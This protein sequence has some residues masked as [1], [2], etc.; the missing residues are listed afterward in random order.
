[1]SKSKG[2]ASDGEGPPWR[3]WVDEFKED[4]DQRVREKTDAAQGGAR[5]V[6]G[7]AR[8]LRGGVEELAS[9]LIEKWGANAVADPRHGGSSW[10]GT[11]GGD[12]CADPSDH[13]AARFR[14][15]L[16]ERFERE[17]AAADD[18]GKAW[19]ERVRDF[20]NNTHEWAD[21]FAQRW[22][23]E[24]AT[25][26]AESAPDNHGESFPEPPTAGAGEREDH[27]APPS[28]P[29]TAVSPATSTTSAA[30]A[31]IVD[32]I[33]IPVVI[34]S[35]IV[36]AASPPRR[37]RAW[38]VGSAAV[39]L[40]AVFAGVVWLVLP[41]GDDPVAATAR[42]PLGGPP[43]I[44]APAAALGVS[45]TA[46]FVGVDEYDHHLNLANPVGDVR[47]IADEMS[48]HY[49]ADV[50]TLENPT[51]AEFLMA[52]S[53]L[54]T[55][56]Y[57]ANSQLL[58]YFAGHGWFDTQQKRGFLA[59]KDSK[60]LADDPLRDTLV[61]HEV[62]RTI[63]ERLD[64]PHVLLMVDSCFG[65]ALD[66]AVAMARSGGEVYRPVSRPEYLRDKLRHRTR[67]YLSAGGREYV[68]DGRPGQHSPFSRGVLEA[69]RS[70][71]GD[72]GVLTIEQVYYR[73][74]A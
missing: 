74:F 12:S 37:G 35:E 13:V 15:E 72:Y 17:V 63:L 49:G 5:A 73:R 6:A 69:L 39:L 10:A 32:P 27:T 22:A 14:T 40:A 38:R 11:V 36:V 42:A 1:M 59:L 25:R 23:D 7:R 31:Q 71:G 46:L 65:G 50:E 57:D 30:V 44:A 3:R 18:L 28:K 58:V 52:L 56:V 47:A 67:L 34:P 61:P 4:L 2:F 29:S 45:T 54:A 43:P 53:R 8:D 33:E 55:N 16:A 51:R 20:Q 64:C 60:T 19:Q 48:R 9:E 66:Y 70:Y 41:K 62:V 26:Q 68:P 21:Q 24:D